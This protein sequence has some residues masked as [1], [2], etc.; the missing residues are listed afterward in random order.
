[1]AAAAPAMSVFIVS[2]PCAVLIERPPESKVIAFPIM[3]TGLP[4]RDGD[5]PGS[6]RRRQYHGARS[7]VAEVIERLLRVLLARDADQRQPLGADLSVRVQR[8]G[9]TLAPSEL[10]FACDPFEQVAE[11]EIGQL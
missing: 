4:R 6:G 9:R 8:E 7:G 11:P 3:A 1:M 10:V 2:M 5:R